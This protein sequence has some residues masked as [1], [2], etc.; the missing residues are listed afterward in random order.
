ML[1]FLLFYLH[2]SI[3]KFIYNPCK[4]LLIL[5]D[6]SSLLIFAFGIVLLPLVFTRM[7]NVGSLRKNPYL[8]LVM[9]GFFVLI[10]FIAAF[11]IFSSAM[12]L[13][14]L[15]F[16]SLLM[17]PFLI[18]LLEKEVP[19]ERTVK[20]KK[21]NRLY[22]WFSPSNLSRIFE[23]HNL[24]IKVYIFLFFGMAPEYAL[25]FAVLQPSIGDY[26]FQHQLSLFGPAGQFFSS[27]IFSQIVENNLQ[28]AIVSFAL[29]IFYGAGSILILN[30]NASIVGVMY[31]SS[32]RT[33]IWGTPL[34]YSNILLY[35]PHTVIEITAYLLAAVAG[36]LLV[37]GLRKDIIHDAAVLF[38]LSIILILLGGY[39]ESIMLA[40]IA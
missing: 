19:E 31:G 23:R 11:F 24:L 40:G 10:G 36:G 37:K 38:A 32:F 7:I 5:M 6:I 9:A 29:S 20:N 22:D 28:I 13:I 21:R 16:S 3:K 12:S 18:K 4:V 1:I 34:F 39:V 14:M 30:Y 25:L 17:L 26:A 27:D 33:L 15:A 2:L 8:A 35:I